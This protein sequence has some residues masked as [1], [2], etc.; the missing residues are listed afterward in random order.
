MKPT[1]SNHTVLMLALLALLSTLNLQL[2]TVFAQG[3]AF[4]Y[5]GRL[6]NNGSPATGI[7]DLRF[8]IYDAV[9][10]GNVVS[11]VLTNTATPV[12]NGLFAVTLDFGN[13][14]FTGPARWLE[15]DVRTNGSGAFTT[16]LPRQ[17]ILPTPYAIMANTASNLL[18]TLPVAQLGAGTANINISGNAST[19]TSATSA[20][21]AG[22][23]AT[24]TT[25]NNFSGPL[26]GDVTGTQSATVV[27]TV[28]GVTAANVAGG[29]NAANAATSLNTAI[30]L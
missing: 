11:G 12:T 25:A 3:T 28:G 29:A 24:A 19:A 26:L 2:S 14:V 27:S 20:T 10:N 9:T 30:R 15:L 5:Q 1:K 7:Y 17:Q 21:T 23:A 4:S 13:G 8:T 16:L 6:N 18:G 22:S